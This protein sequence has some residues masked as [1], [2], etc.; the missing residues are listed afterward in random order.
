MLNIQFNTDTSIKTFARIL[1]EDFKKISN[2]YN[3]SELENIATNDTL[4][5]T[6]KTDLKSDINMLIEMLNSGKEVLPK[7]LIAKSSDINNEVSRALKY[8]TP[9][10]ITIENKDDPNDKY[11]LSGTFF[12]FE[13]K[14]QII[15]LSRNSYA[16]RELQLELIRLLYKNRFIN[17]KLRVFDSTKPNELYILE[18]FGSLEV[19]G[20]QNQPFDK[21]SD[22]SNGVEANFLDIIFRENYFKLSDETGVMLKYEI[23]P[24][25]DGL[26]L[27]PIYGGI[28]RN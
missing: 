28:A 6:V 23:L 2:V 24:T 17:Y 25:I 7:I 16:K 27:P 5:Q 26:E 14:G 4:V 11:K 13:T 20:F 10:I 3:I 22:E 15:V 1:N 8:Q 18:D 21:Q 19:L 9:E 12:E